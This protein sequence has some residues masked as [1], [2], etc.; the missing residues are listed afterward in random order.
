[1]WIIAIS[2]SSRGRGKTRSSSPRRRGPITTA[3]SVPESMGRLR[4]DLAKQKPTEVMGPR[5][6]G[7]D[8]LLSSLQ[9]QHLAREIADR[10]PRRRGRRS[11]AADV[12]IELDAVVLVA[13]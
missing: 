12:R 7:D 5:L 2:A 3:S 11:V 6:R 10:D 9:L 1:M 13:E 4:N 8:S